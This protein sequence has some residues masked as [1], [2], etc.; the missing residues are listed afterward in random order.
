MYP[1]TDDTLKFVPNVSVSK[2]ES[3]P[4]SCI[5]DMGFLYGNAILS[6]Y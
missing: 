3:G 6:L 5:A 2:T 1:P 4:E